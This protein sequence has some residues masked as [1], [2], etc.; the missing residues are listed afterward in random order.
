MNNMNSSSVLQQTPSTIQTPTPPPDSVCPNVHTEIRNHAPSPIRP[1]FPKR[2]QMDNTKPSLVL[3]QTSSSIQTPTRPLDSVPSPISPTLTKS[4]QMNNMMTS[5]V[6]HS[7]INSHDSP[8]ADENVESEVEIS[9]L[10]NEDKGPEQK[11][12]K[13]GSIDSRSSKGKRRDLIRDWPDDIKF[14]EKEEVLTIDAEGKYHKVVALI[15]T[16]DVW[17]SNN[18]KYCVTFNEFGQPLR[19]GGY[20]LIKFIGNVAKNKRFCLIRERNWR[21]VDAQFKIDFIK[22]I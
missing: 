17:H 14:D 12:G 19:A 15:Q 22:I 2:P 5:S 1:T 20:V 13:I 9:V 4:P 21:H 3:Q 7:S 8:L 18:V 10:R 16:H 6:L 11:N